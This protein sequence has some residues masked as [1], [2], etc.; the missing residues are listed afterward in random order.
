MFVKLCKLM[1][2]TGLLTVSIAQTANATVILDESFDAITPGTPFAPGSFND[3]ER[4]GGQYYRAD[5]TIPDWT[6][7][8]A[9]QIFPHVGNSG[10][11][12]LLLNAAGGALL[13]Q[14]SGFTAGSLYRLS[15]EFWADNS[16]GGNTTSF[17]YSLGTSVSGSDAAVSQGRLA[18][19]FY[20]HTVDFTALASDLTLLLTNTSSSGTHFDNITIASLTVDAPNHSALM[21]IALFTLLL[22][23]VI[24]NRARD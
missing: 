11:T 7:I 15:L 23:R 13:R 5:S 24:A 2:I 10:N 20:T 4:E 16:P 17:N 9:S 18:G 22:S 12:S 8:G 19:V 6:L 14:L 1:F 3:T 21:I